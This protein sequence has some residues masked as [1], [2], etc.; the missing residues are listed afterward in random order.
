M[1]RVISSVMVFLL[2]LRCREQRVTGL[3]V[4]LLTG[5][6]VLMSPILKVKRHENVYRS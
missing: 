6:S 3:C 2:C 4:F 1:S 5:L